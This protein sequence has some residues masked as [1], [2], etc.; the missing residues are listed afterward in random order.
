VFKEVENFVGVEDLCCGT[1]PL[2]QKFT[3]KYLENIYGV[4]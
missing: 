1:F 4:A 2:P 3:P